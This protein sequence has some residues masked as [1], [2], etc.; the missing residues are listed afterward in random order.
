MTDSNNASLAYMPLD[1]EEFSA[2]IFGNDS[3]TNIDVN[4]SHLEVV[5]GLA[6]QRFGYILLSLSLLLVIALLILAIDY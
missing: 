4:K 3:F 1:Y 5:V 2:S 6:I